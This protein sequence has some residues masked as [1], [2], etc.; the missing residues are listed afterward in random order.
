[1]SQFLF[2]SGY[3]R[4]LAPLLA[5]PLAIVAEPAAHAQ[6]PAWQTAVISAD[7][8]PNSTVKATATDADGNVYI[9][10]RF[11]GSATFGSTVLTSAGDFDAFIAKWNSATNS[12]VWAQRVGGTGRDEA[13][14]I[15]VSGTNVYLAGNSPA[16]TSLGYAVDF[17]GAPLAGTSTGDT[18]VA[19]LTDAGTFSWA[20]RGAG[21]ATINA[22]AVNGA[23]LYVAGEF[24]RPTTFGSTALT[25]AGG[26][27]VFVAK[28]TDTGTS[29]SYTWAQRAGSSIVDQALA[30]AVNGTDVYVGGFFQLQPTFGGSALTGAPG[31]FVA[32]LTDA[33][34]SGAFTWV[35]SSGGTVSALAVNGP[36]I[37]VTGSFSASNG[38]FG[39]ITLSTGGGF[40]AKLTDAGAGSSYNWALG[41]GGASSIVS[42]QAL[43]VRGTALYIAGRFFGR[44]TPFGT[45][46][47]ATAGRID[48][49]VAKLTDTGAS[50]DFTWAQR[51][52]GVND[53]QATALAVTS[54]RV[55]VAGDFQAPSAD[56]SGTSLTSAAAVNGFLA[57]L[58]EAS[59]PLATY[60]AR[61]ASEPITL[62]PNPAHAGTTL[63]LR[64][65]TENRALVLLDATGRQVRAQTLPAGAAEAPLNVA[66]LAPGLYH[67][68][69]G[70]ASTRLVVE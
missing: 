56:F 14:A 6:A 37:Y 58:P 69:C 11:L 35:Q 9:T 43:A 44:A 55:F 18:F 27:D 20:L 4:A 45:T 49:F 1:M 32:K 23:N 50:A 30:L 12:F 39:T 2:S 46:I 33:G 59:G 63:N 29:A 57:A 60:T 28:L 13:T 24:G 42:A 36:N 26:S 10:G 70:A 68:R 61:Q 64:A 21:E 8:A 51:A 40:V 7:G 65:A 31:G 3:R 38:V 16:S 66:G 47:L 17:G 52:G 34:A 5:L 54:T 62:A 25:S 15:V 19:R 67:V 22:L 53:D 41:L 48:I